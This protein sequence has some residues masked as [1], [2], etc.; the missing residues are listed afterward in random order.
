MLRPSA[1]GNGAQVCKVAMSHFDY[2]K[3]KTAAL[4]AGFQ[5]L[6]PGG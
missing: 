3:K 6:W 5:L 2:P 4:S 1:P